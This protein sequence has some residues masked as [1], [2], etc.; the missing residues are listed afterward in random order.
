MPTI[1]LSSSSLRILLGF[2]AGNENWDF[3]GLYDS[4]GASGFHGLSVC[5]EYWEAL[6]LVQ[7]QTKDAPFLSVLFLCL[8]SSLEDSCLQFQLWSFWTFS[9]QWSQSDFFLTASV[10]SFEMLSSINFFVLQWCRWWSWCSAKLFSELAGIKSMCNS[11]C[12]FS[13]Q[14]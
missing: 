13:L 12:F 7:R 11:F 6:I 3:F 14:Q 2:V 9:F 10:S 4:L 8:F 5:R 1:H